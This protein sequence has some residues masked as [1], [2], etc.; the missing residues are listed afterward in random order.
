[1][2]TN[3]SI[4]ESTVAELV[5][6]RKKHEFF[7]KLIDAELAKRKGN[8]SSVIV[9]VKPKKVDAVKK[10]KKSPEKKSPNKDLSA[11]RADMITILSKRSV[12]FKPS[13]NKSDLT[14]LI[15]KNG[16]VRTV[17]SHHEQRTAKA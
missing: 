10:E 7:I 15:R 4:T 6:R 2:S 8:S 9:S 12:D 14:A 13:M 17:E 3:K 11:T 1:M 16:L 5:E